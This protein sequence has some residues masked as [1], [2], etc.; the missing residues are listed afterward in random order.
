MRKLYGIFWVPLLAAVVVF[1]PGIS[2]STDVRSLNRAAFVNPT[3][4]A[5]SPGVDGFQLAFAV[6]TVSTQAELEFQGTSLSSA[7]FT[8]ICGSTGLNCLCDFFTDANG[9]GKISSAEG[10]TTYSSTGNFLRCS[11]P[12]ATPAT[13]THARVRDR[14]NLRFTNTVEITNQDNPDLT[15]RLTLQKVLGDLQAVDVRKIS[16][17]RCYI[18]YLRKTGTTTTFFSCAAAALSIVQVPYYFY[19]YADNLSNNFASRRADILHSDGSG[20]LCQSLV[21]F[22]DCSTVDDGPTDPNQITLRFGIYNKSQGLFNVPIQ[23]TNAPARAGGVNTGYGFA[24]RYDTTLNRCPPGLEA[25]QAFTAQPSAAIADS[26]LNQT[27]VDRR[28]LVMGSSSNFLVDEFTGGT[29]NGTTC[30]P[31]NYDRDSATPANLQNVA[32]VAQTASTND[33]VCVLPAS[34]LTGI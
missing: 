29:C 1:L 7:V 13:Y 2:C 33:R 27:L 14:S 17:Y 4:S 12:S 18:N 19:L 15:K 21:K 22:I 32:Y 9:S 20:L 31:P 6:R 5:T 8:G 25:W 23:L 11:V 16:E 26:Q 3:P 24:A 10:S 34:L 30:T 28:M